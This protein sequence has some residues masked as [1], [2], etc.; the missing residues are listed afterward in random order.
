MHDKQ[1]SIRDLVLEYFKN[2]PNCDLPHGPVVDWVEEQ[3]KT[4]YG[5]KPRDTWRTI[6]H[7]HEEGILVKVKKGIY[8][9]DPKRESPA[10]VKD[11]SAEQKRQIFERDGYR[12]VICGKGREDGVELHV[13]HIRPRALGGTSDI[14]NGQTLC[15]PC[16]LRKKR[17]S[18]TETGKRMFIR[19][20]EAARKYNDEK[21]MQFCQEVLSLYEKHG[22]NDHITWQTDTEE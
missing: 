8:R 2:Y 7:L 20:Y 12:C 19:L 9:Y 3:Y 10:R 14:A 13:D 15:A 18:Q 17:Y 16:N 5:R 11:F 6:R 22:I 1:K 21:V 4:L